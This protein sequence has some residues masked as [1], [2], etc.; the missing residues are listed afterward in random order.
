M[1]RIGC[2]DP[3]QAALSRALGMR[4]RPCT[5]GEHHNRHFAAASQSGARVFV[6]LL[7]DAGFW[8]RAI[9]AAPM[10]ELYGGR[11]P[12]LLDHGELGDDRWWLVYEWAQLRPF[13]ATAK[14]IE[15]AGALLGWLHRSTAGMHLDRDFQRH[16][17]HEEITTRAAA[18]HALNPAAAERVF[19]AQ[20]RW[21]DVDL[22]EEVCV[23]H[24]D[25]QWRNLGID[26]GGEVIL[27]D[28]ENCSSGHAA[29]DFGKLV[30]SEL[31][32]PADR[33]AFLRGYDRHAA[34]VH[35]WPPAM[36]L[37]RLWTTTGILVY[38]LSRGLPDLAEHGYSVLA[39]LEQH[40]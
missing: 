16:D 8:G 14:Q 20:A 27:Y 12:R 13:T 15:Q 34:R 31:A 38:A 32:A 25:V 35:P 6:K 23:V 36:H 21:G 4:L 9:R 26:R 2:E 10:A 1:I 5:R 17:L 22:S 24:G 40:T 7:D 18:L 33:D 28:W 29:L 11:T 3:E 37:V 30:D 19:A 39:D